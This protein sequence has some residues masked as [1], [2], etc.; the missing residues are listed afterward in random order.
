MRSPI[1]SIGSIKTSIRSL[2]GSD[3][4]WGAH[5]P[6]C[7]RHAHHLIW[8]KGHPF[9]LGCTCM[10]SGIALG[11][12]VAFAIDWSFFT[13]VGWV[14]FHFALL[15]PT[16]GQPALQKKPYKIIS[17]LL[18]GVCVTTYWLSGIFFFSPSLVSVWLFRFLVIVAFVI[19]FQIMFQYRNKFVDNPCKGC[20]LGEYPTCD[21]NLP[22]L[23]A[24]NSELHFLKESINSQPD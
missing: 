6:H 16:M 8:V 14:L 7:E 18:L 17:R 9:C 24:E 10:Y 15:I 5:H 21:W 2:H 20:P 3:F 22:R 1:V 4:L 23:L 11:I 19:N 13:F 12:P